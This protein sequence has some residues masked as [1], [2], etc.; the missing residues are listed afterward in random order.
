MIQSR[1]FHLLHT[2]YVHLI[3]VSI[4]SC[5][6]NIL[7]HNLTNNSI[8]RMHSSVLLVQKFRKFSLL[9]M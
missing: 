8:I 9:A 5:R 2:F 7:T 6:Y 1:P 3:A 4:R